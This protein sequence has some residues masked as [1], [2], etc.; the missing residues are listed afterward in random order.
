MEEREKRGDEE[1]GERSGGLESVA[2]D[3]EMC[4][5]SPGRAR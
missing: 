2:K 1:E 4:T 3:R 5:A